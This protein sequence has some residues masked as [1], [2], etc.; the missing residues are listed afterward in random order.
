MRRRMLITG[1]S[2]YLGTWLVHQARTRWDVIATY[3]RGQDDQRGVTW[4]QLDVRD[5]N[6]VTA[7]I[8]EAAPDVV[9]H[10]AAANPGADPDYDGVNV[11]GTRHV[12]RAA[13]RAAA[14]LVHVSTDVVFDGEDAPYTESDPPRPLTAYGRSKAQAEVEVRASGADFMMVRT[15]LIYGWRPAD[16]M[17]PQES[18]GWRT[19]TSIHRRISLSHLG[20]EPD[21]GLAGTGRQVDHPGRAPRGRHAATLALRFWRATCSVPRR[22]SNPHHRGQQP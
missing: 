16:D 12:A 17:D 10:A 15:L 14:R 7:L 3:F 13:A 9:V 5:A 18:G 22:R 4:R 8:D 20:G 21:G 2:G 6:A 19:A 1:G 11:Q